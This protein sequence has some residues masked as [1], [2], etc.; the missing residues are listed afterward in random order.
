MPKK[1]YLSEENYERMNKKIKKIAL[2]VW[3]VGLLIGLSL[4]SAGLIR[5]LNK[6]NIANDLA[7]KISSAEEVAEKYDKEIEV[8]EDEKSKL[9]QEKTQIFMSTSC[10][11][12]CDEYYEKENEIKQK[13]KEIIAKQN[14]KEKAIKS[15]NEGKTISDLEYEQSNLEGGIYESYS[16]PFFIFGGF[17][18]IASSMYALMIFLITK[19]R[20]IAAYHIQSV[21]PVAKE[22]VEKATPVVA[23]SMGKI[24]KSVSENI[25]KGIK[26]GK[27]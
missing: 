1:E 8:L 18:I 21:A 26:E 20:A 9:D 6:D 23:D 25:T 12:F 5:N 14:E 13:T 10:K 27:K 2:T 4:I 7:A 11:G 17:A 24:A 3:L 19:R 16:I 22:G 15:L